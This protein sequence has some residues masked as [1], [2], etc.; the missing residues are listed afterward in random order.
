MHPVKALLLVLALALVSGGLVSYR[1][2]TYR[3][4]VEDYL[5]RAGDAPSVDLASAALATAMAN[6]AERGLTHGN[7]SWFIDSPANDV[8][9][10]FRQLEAA[11]QELKIAQKEGTSIASSNAL[12][13]L[14]E[15][16]DSQPKNLQFHPHVWG[17]ALLTGLCVFALVCSAVGFVAVIQ[18]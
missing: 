7:T 5:K 1:S 14:R 12:M 4:H 13:K 18:D 10:W 11:Q 3:L 17:Y 6:A 8:A 15:A 2:I 9:Y 16:L